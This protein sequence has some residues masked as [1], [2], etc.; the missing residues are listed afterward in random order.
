MKFLTLCFQFDF[1]NSV[2]SAV[3]H[4]KSTLR[5]SFVLLLILAST[6]CS[7]TPE[8]IPTPPTE[9]VV[10]IETIEEYG[11]EAD[12]SNRGVLIYL[13]KLS[14]AFNSAVLSKEA[15]SKL[16]YIARICN[17]EKAASRSIVVIGHS[18]SKGDEEYNL[19]LSRKRAENVSSDL[20]SLG[21]DANRITIEWYGEARPIIPN[22]LA[23]GKDN[24]EGR[25]ANRR[26][27]IVLLNP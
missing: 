16:T 12:E 21:V 7:T 17:S 25:A 13:P 22:K 26:V 14:F 19:A 2:S 27:E 20:S 24:P 1:N 11:L 10:L 15:K 8:P 3:S 4:F 23:D 5:T 18:D 6:A 9:N